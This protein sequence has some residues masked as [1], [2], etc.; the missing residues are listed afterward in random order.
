[1]SHFV[2][3]IKNNLQ[4]CG[5]LLPV[6]LGKIHCAFLKFILDKWYYFFISGMR[7]LQMS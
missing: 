1:M 7:E 6:V 2:P 3:F 4:N 5:R